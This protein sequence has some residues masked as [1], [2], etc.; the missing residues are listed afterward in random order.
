MNVLLFIPVFYGFLKRKPGNL[1]EILMQDGLASF[2]DISF[3]D[4]YPLYGQ[5]DIVA[6]S[7]A[8]NDA[9]QKDLLDQLELI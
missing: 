4:I 2:K 7:E 1:S 8:R 5:I 6:S 3:D 9:I